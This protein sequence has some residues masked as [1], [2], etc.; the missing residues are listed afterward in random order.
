M[1]KATKVPG[2]RF[3]FTI[4]IFLNEKS[5]YAAPFL[6]TYLCFQILINFLVAASG[7][8]A[9]VLV[10]K[11]YAVA[12]YLVACLLAVATITIYPAYRYI[13]ELDLGEGEL[14]GRSIKVTLWF[15]N[16][17]NFLMAAGSFGSYAGLSGYGMIFGYQ[18]YNDQKDDLGGILLGSAM[19]LGGSAGILPVFLL[20]LNQFLMGFLAFEAERW[21]NKDHGAMKL[22]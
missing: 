22:E 20:T 13:K 17:I 1:G 15:N 2:G 8:L 5:L 11:T 9:G 12:T 18:K 16:F 19:F 14:G 3:I 10:I 6:K 4:M 21:L 7:V